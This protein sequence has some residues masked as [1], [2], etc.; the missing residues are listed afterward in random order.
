MFPAVPPT[1][2]LLEV[3]C[4]PSCHWALVDTELGHAVNTH[5]ICP[6][7]LAIITVIVLW[8]C[9]P[10]FQSVCLQPILT[11]YIIIILCLLHLV[12][13]FLL[14]PSQ[15]FFLFKPKRKL[16]ARRF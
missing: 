5:R 1:K 7:L 6:I 9:L 10:C 8:I 2:A 14:R 11:R 4:H 13:G 15:F 3:A 16:A 12:S